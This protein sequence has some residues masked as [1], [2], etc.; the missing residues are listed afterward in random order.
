M[1]A[2]SARCRASSSARSS[3]R[4]PVALPQPEGPSSTR[5]S[6]SRTS[7]ESSC[8]AGRAPPSNVFV[9]P[10]KVTDA[11]RLS[12]LGASSEGNR[13]R[14]ADVAVPRRAAVD[15]DA[16]ARAV[17]RYRYSPTGHAHAL[18][19]GAADAKRHGPDGETSPWTV[20]Q[21]AHHVRHD[22]VIH[23]GVQVSG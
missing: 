1:V 14:V 15:L 17:D 4:S 19:Y 22:Q 16:E 7:S 6:P 18:E 12:L 3:P 10:R 5:N 9:R 8:N 21:H 20:R 2:P 13:Q 11:M 23:P